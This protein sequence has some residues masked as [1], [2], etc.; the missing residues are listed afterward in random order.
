MIQIS[1]SAIEYF[2]ALLNDQQDLYVGIRMLAVRPGTVEADCQLAYCEE[3]DIEADDLRLS[4][5]GVS[6]IVDNES[7]AW[8]R[9]AHVDYQSNA[10]G[11][12]LVVRAPHLKIKVPAADA[13]LAERVEYLINAEINPQLARHKGRVS[14][15]T[16]TPD[17]YAVLRFGGGC[18]GCGMV[19]VTLKE[20][21][22][23]TFKSHLPELAGVR[24]ETDHVAGEAPWFRKASP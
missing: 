3:A 12:Q 23:K 20:G 11:G 4:L 21:I 14:L 1:A 16:V 5:G 7:A 8:L 9:D 17:R 22:E 6:V 13:P 15:I 18:Q 10:L 19:D 24:D 2:R